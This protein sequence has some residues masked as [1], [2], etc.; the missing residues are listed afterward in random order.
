LP[1]RLYTP[2]LNIGIDY[3]LLGQYDKA[4]ETSRKALE[5]DP[6]AQLNYAAVARFFAA[7]G[8]L[9]ESKQIL[10]QAFNFGMDSVTLRAIQANIGFLE[11]D[12]ATVQRNLEWS[13][14]RAGSGLLFVSRASM[15][16]YYGKLR[17]S[18]EFFQQAVEEAKSRHSPMRAAN[19]RAQQAN[20][21]AM[22]GKLKE[23][24]ALAQAALALDGTA[25]SQNAVASVFA[26][27]GDMAIVQRTIELLNREF[28]QDTLIQNQRIP[29]L[30]SMIERDPSKAV[31][32]LEPARPTELGGFGLTPV[33][34]RGMA[35][36][37]WGKGAE[38]AA[39]FQKILAHRTLAPLSLAH[40]LSQLGLARARVLAGDTAGARS[41]YQDFLALW[42]DADP[43]I[44]ILQQ[45]KAE[46]AKLK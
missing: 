20:A 41:T 28:P 7:Q 21:E 33:Y 39:E 29:V 1:H 4:L 27:A 31:E 17:E 14:G 18:E 43:D 11:G 46:Y 8:R 36:L 37:R 44:P 34:E 45:A 25:D 42:K 26:Q 30:R 24:K 22:V 35:Y 15:A 9:D 6:A 40:P 10:Q 19:Y 32:D 23:S 2:R 3:G 12:M 38:A 5:L 16:V 13:K